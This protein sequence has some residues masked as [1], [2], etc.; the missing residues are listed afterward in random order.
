M[1]RLDHQ[2]PTCW[3]ASHIACGYFSLRQYGHL[4]HQ[5]LA[6]LRVVRALNRLQ[7]RFGWTVERLHQAEDARLPCFDRS[8]QNSSLLAQIV[9]T[10][11]G[12]SGR[13]VGLGRNQPPPPNC[14]LSLGVYAD[15]YRPRGRGNVNVKVCL[16]DEG[17][18]LFP[19][20]AHIP[21]CTLLLTWREMLKNDNDQ[22][23]RQGRAEELNKLQKTRFCL[24]VQVG[25]LH[26]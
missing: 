10:L 9:G 26:A 17:G 15:G 19:I 8:L 23:V 22:C 18:S 20:R 3:P 4:R 21:Q 12:G 11:F 6:S 5:G 16:I 2:T 25:G 1:C 24:P 7:P 14:V 13:C